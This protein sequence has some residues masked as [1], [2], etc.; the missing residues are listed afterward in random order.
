MRV[1]NNSFDELREFFCKGLNKCDENTNFRYALTV[2]EE[3][4]KGLGKKL[5]EELEK[6][7]KVPIKSHHKVG[8]KLKNVK[9]IVDTIDEINYRLKEARIGWTFDVDA[10]KF[11]E[12]I[13]IDNDVTYQLAVKPA[14]R[15]LSDSRFQESASNFL[16]AFESYQEGSQKG[17]ESAVDYAVKAL[18]STIRN[19]CVIKEYSIDKNATLKPLIQTLIDNK[20]LPKYQDD[21]LNALPKIFMTGGGVIGN[22]ET[23]HGKEDSKAKE[24]SALLT[25]N[26]V[27][28][29][30]SQT[31]STIVFL[32]GIATQMQPENK[33]DCTKE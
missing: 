25:D 17:R 9:K 1:I 15:L 12:L 30:L 31:A 3:I 26:L 13:R 6:I 27:N 19:I 2:V 24:T 32:V 14:F 10:G 11:G 7:N 29:V 16:K 18:E 28:F 22:R 5:I 4:C 8:E 33:N 20:F 21:F 23:R